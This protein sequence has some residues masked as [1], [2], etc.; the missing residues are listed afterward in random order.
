[1]SYATREYYTNAYP[2]KYGDI[3]DAAC[4]RT[5]IPRSLAYA[6]VY[7]E[8]G[9]KPDAV[10]DAGARGLM[11]LVPDAFDWVMMLNGEKTR[12]ADELFDPA[13]NVDCGT[14]LLRRLLDEF[15]TIPNALCAYHAGRGR[16]LS[17]LDDPQISPDGKNVVNIPFDDTRAYVA[18]VMSA[19]RTYQR[20]Y[21]ME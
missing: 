6:V 21:N 15:E 13:T 18:K 11:Q 5:R 10:S 9:F 3:I 20:L 7:T 12:H 19:M 1:M 16:V 17:W 4:E 14:R 8:S 2:V